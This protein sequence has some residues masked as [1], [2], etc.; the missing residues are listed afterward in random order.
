[1][2]LQ[3]GTAEEYIQEVICTPDKAE[4]RDP[5]HHNST[6]CLHGLLMPVYLYVKASALIG[7]NC[8][9]YTFLPPST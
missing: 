9:F 3:W 6:I 8:N 5:K 4:L 2:I 1:M 7:S